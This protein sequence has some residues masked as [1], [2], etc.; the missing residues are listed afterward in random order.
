MQIF[1]NKH[2][3]FAFILYVGC[4]L[5]I[6]LLT[7]ISAIFNLPNSTYVG[8]H[9]LLLPDYS[10]FAL[11]TSLIL[12]I[13]VL[14]YFIVSTQTIYKNNAIFIIFVTAIIIL[15]LGLYPPIYDPIYY[16]SASYAWIYKGINVFTSLVVYYS[17]NPFPF[18]N[19]PMI[20][21][22]AYGP[23]W[24]MISG[25]IT[26]ISTNS[27]WV[28]LFILRVITTA[29]LALI[30][31]LVKRMQP[32][33]K[34][35][36][37]ILFILINPIIVLFGIPSGSME[38]LLVLFAILSILLIKD[39]RFR[40]ACIILPIP[41]FIKIS[42]LP[43]ILIL[44]GWLITK[45]NKQISLI[46]QI[47][48]MAIPIVVYIFIITNIFG[49]NTNYFQGISEFFNLEKTHGMTIANVFSYA[50]S[51]L[52]SFP[53]AHYLIRFVINNLL[54]IIYGLIFLLLLTRTTFHHPPDHENNI[55]RRIWLIM[56]V[57]LALTGIVIKPWY[58]IPPTII[59]LLLPRQ[60]QQISLINILLIII[61][62]LFSSIFLLFPNL[63]NFAL[64]LMILVV[65]F[66]AV[67][68][69]ILS[70]LVFR[71][72]NPVDLNSNIS[73][74]IKKIIPIIR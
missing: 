50:I 61:A 15:S 49:V 62:D 37:L 67:I 3:S 29:I 39:N 12:A 28:F 43:I 47:I 45:L 41:I 8:P 17:N 52:F 32:A 74:I 53:N 71:E 2:N 19:I 25:L 21:N 38:I 42:T 68:P 13:A 30:V 9:H 1:S 27:F 31:I 60:Y 54:I 65:L 24:L 5:G 55:V 20:H 7:P 59:S 44:Y 36:S 22:Y 33:L 6:T 40:L 48:L 23:F 4:I 58:A 35:Q 26:L 14:Y 51:Q 69:T 56:W 18:T 70:L 57:S 11:Y 10:T 16:F 46:K 66:S 64:L 63:S 72:I 73:R 34:N